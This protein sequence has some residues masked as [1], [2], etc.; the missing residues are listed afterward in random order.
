MGERDRM[1][2]KHDA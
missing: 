2:Q 1:P